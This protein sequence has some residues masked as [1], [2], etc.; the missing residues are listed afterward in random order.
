MFETMYTMRR[1]E[2]T[3]VSSTIPSSERNCFYLIC[4]ELPQKAHGRTR[5]TLFAHYTNCIR[6]VAIY[7]NR[8]M[9]TR[10]VTFAA[11]AT[12]TMV[13]KPSLLA[14]SGRLRRKTRG[15]Q[16]TVATVSHSFAEAALPRLLV[17]FSATLTATRRARVVVCTSTTKN[18]TFSV[19]KAL[20]A[21]KC[22]LEQVWH[23]PISTRRPPV[24]K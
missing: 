4:E 14:F 17:N 13:R 15:L 5:V 21:P 18:I 24:K 7:H 8:I 22:Q 11:F 19:D 12:Y 6:L 16:A 10:P 2:I 3:C 9:N 20:L 23:L 1:M